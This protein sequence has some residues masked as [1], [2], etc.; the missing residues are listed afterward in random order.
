M[1]GERSVKIQKS[2]FSQINHKFD[3]TNLKK[4]VKLKYDFAA[5]PSKLQRN[6][7]HTKLINLKI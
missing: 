5:S 7:P 4:L 2:K 1:Y 6:K 3:V